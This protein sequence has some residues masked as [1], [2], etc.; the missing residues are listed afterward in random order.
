MTDRLPTCRHCHRTMAPGVSCDPLAFDLAD[1]TTA[2]RLRYG[3][4]GSGLPWQDPCNDCGA[5]LGGYHH[6]GCDC[7]ICP[8][9]QALGC[10]DCRTAEPDRQGGADAAGCQAPANDRVG[11]SNRYSDTSS[12]DRMAASLFRAPPFRESVFRVTSHE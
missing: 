5:P 6:A 4:D 1:G 12:K 8:H 2:P 9:G 7:D 11:G 10:G 3:F